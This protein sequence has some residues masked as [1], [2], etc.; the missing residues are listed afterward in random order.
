[1]MP[2]S[3]CPSC[4]P[5]ESP[6]AVAVLL[7]ICKPDDEAI[8]LPT[9]HVADDCAQRNTDIDSKRVADQ[10]SQH[11]AYVAVSQLLAVRV[12]DSSADWV[13][14]LL[15]FCK[16]DDGAILPTQHVTDEC[17]QRHTDVDSKRDADQC[18]QHDDAYVA[19][20]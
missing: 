17:A 5:S 20:S 3:Q 11:D 14:V 15:S 8:I 12:S 19:V 9:Q 16:P 7:S 13:A 2:T 18:S 4:S 1:M 10:C 6:T